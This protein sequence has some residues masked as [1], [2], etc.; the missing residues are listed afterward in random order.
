MEV[1][2]GNLTKMSYQTRADGKR[3]FEEI[4]EMLKEGGEKK[5]LLE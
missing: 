4:G 3:F 2:Y 1:K 5:I